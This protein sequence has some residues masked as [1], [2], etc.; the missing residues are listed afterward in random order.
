M[1]INVND[2]NPSLGLKYTVF[3]AK[4]VLKLNEVYCDT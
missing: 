1:K 3:V 4:L 2:F